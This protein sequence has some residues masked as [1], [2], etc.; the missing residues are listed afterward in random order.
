MNKVEKSLLLLIL[1]MSLGGYYTANY[2][3]FSQS[4]LD[5]MKSTGTIPKIM[6]VYGAALT[7]NYV[8]ICTEIT[9]YSG[10]K[11]ELKIP[12]DIKA[13]PNLEKSYSSTFNSLTISEKNIRPGCD[14]SERTNL[15]VETVKVAERKRSHADLLF[16]EMKDTVPPK[17]YVF[18]GKFSSIIVDLTTDPRAINDYTVK[19]KAVWKKGSPIWKLVLHFSY[20]ADAITYPF[21]FLIV[22]F[23]GIGQQKITGVSAQKQNKQK[24]GK[25]LI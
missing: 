20:L 23:I 2:G 9:T 15:E 5:E 14:G 21:Q 3:Y 19:L 10:Q 4:T 18:E 17:I 24:I 13:H 8:L 1:Y 25:T 12:R 16:R 11:Y 7:E 22:V 6:N